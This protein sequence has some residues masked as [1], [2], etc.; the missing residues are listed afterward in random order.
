MSLPTRLFVSITT[1]VA[2]A[3][4]PLV[5][6]YIVFANVAHGGLVTDFEQAF[7]P[8]AEALL[9]G[10][11]PYPSLD[12]PDIAA[13]RAYV[14][15][16]LTAIATIPLTAL[17]VDAAGFVVM[18]LLVAM[19]VGTLVALGVRDWRCYGLAFLWPPV[20]SSIQTGNIT[21]PLALGAALAW[22]FRD[23]S[24]AAG[25][26]VGLSL[27]AKLILWPLLLWL[28][29]LGRLR[30]V[31]IS[32]AVGVAT[33][34]VS[35]AAIGFDAVGRY[36]DLLRRLQELEEPEGY[37]VYAL[38]FDLGASSTVSRAL[39]VAVAGALLAGVVV[40]GRRGDD[41]RAFV[42][43]VAAALACSPIVW[44]HYFALLLVAV[45][46]AQPR[47]GPAWFAP[48]LMYFSTGTY[49]GST[50]QTAITIGAAV[51]TVAAAMRLGRSEPA[52]ARPAL[53][54]RGPLT[55]RST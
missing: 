48:L 2:L 46:V 55:E 31:V 45:A 6:L 13:G 28:A 54:A 51:L 50:F 35:W 8:A 40:L 44:L 1:A 43:A 34:A 16:P 53:V 4:L 33:V 47:L 37:T 11:D 25:V 52:T 7:Y 29:V 17:S 3:F 20:L 41:R 27:A 36:P 24:L 15:P 21:I 14:Y 49:N 32:L 30:A 5:A 39:G 26:S 10:E 38:A 18:A 9:D 19:V 12:D 42:L 22:R 23:R